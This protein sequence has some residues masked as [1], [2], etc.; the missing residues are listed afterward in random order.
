MLA[1]LEF[2]RGSLSLCPSFSLLKCLSNLP[3]L[4]K[5]DCEAEAQTSVLHAWNIT[6]ALSLISL[7]LP[8][9][10]GTHLSL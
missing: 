9:P 2:A 8:I 5:S 10:S 6:A 4:L 3:F 1:I 7:S